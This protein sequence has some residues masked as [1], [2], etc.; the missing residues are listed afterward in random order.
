MPTLFD[1]D[2]CFNIELPNHKDD[3]DM[4][5]EVTECHVMDVTMQDVAY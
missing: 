1:D 4:I 5:L 3:F 2:N